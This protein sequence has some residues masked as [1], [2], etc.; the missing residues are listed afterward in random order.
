MFDANDG[1]HNPALR[2]MRPGQV[3]DHIGHVHIL[4]HGEVCQVDAATYY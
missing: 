4:N 3:V 1:F 2:G